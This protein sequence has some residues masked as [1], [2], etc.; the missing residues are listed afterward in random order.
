MKLLFCRKRRKGYAR[1]RFLALPK[2]GGGAID[3][4][5]M[6]KTWSAT[7]ATVSKS[8]LR[9]SAPWGTPPTGWVTALGSRLVASIRHSQFPQWPDRM[10]LSAHNCGA[11]TVSIIPC[12]ATA[13]FPS[14]LP[15]L[16]V[17]RTNAGNKV[18]QRL[19]KIDTGNHTTRTAPHASH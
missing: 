15:S 11:A 8:P 19:R 5:S 18:W 16:A 7:L 6:K 10:R 12:G 14:Y 2:N 17:W 3:L 13:R 4:A 9:K 1:G